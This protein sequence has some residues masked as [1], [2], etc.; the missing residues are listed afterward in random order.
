MNRWM[1]GA[2]L[3]VVGLSFAGGAT[4]QTPKAAEKKPT[5]QDEFKSLIDRYYAA[6]NTGNPD[7]AAP[8]YAQD[9]DSSA[10]AQNRPMS[11]T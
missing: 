4:G 8:L 7:N 9:K 1:L 10:I 2:L 6:W 11:I 5:Q 3:I